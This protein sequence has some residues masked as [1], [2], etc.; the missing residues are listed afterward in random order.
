LQPELLVHLL[1]TLI[2]VLKL[3]QAFVESALSL[4]KLGDFSALTIGF[5]L[6]QPPLKKVE[7]I[8]KGLN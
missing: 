4:L 7:I 3:S 2:L 8:L 6:V 5:G 1:V